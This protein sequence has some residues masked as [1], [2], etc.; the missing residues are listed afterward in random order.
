MHFSVMHVI[1]RYGEILMNSA[2]V[3]YVLV[4]FYINNNIHYNI[5]MKQDDYFL[6][7]L[8]FFL[9]NCRI[10]KCLQCTLLKVQS[11]EICDP[12]TEIQK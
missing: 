3:H 8:F 5:K 11:E 7:S 1:Q 9:G 10:I 2:C 6:Q 4:Q 12:Q